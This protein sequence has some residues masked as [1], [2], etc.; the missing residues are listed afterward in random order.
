MSTRFVLLSE[1]LIGVQSP[2]LPSGMLDDLLAVA[3]ANEEQLDRI[4]ADLEQ[5]PGIPTDTRL[6]EVITR[7]VGEVPLAESIL[8]AVVNL[9]PERLEDTIQT[10]RHWREASSANAKKLPPDRLE[11]IQ[12]RL[13][14][15]IRNY[16]ALARYRKAQR[17]KTLTGKTADSVELIC[18]LRP[19]FDQSRTVVEGLIPLATLRLSYQGTDGT[20]VLEVFL[21]GE[22]L[23]DLAD[24]VDKAKQKL[25]TLREVGE[26]WVPNGWVAPE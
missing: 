4:A 7:H 19:V 24:E 9:R 8:R 1:G 13:T 14:R 25:Q 12:D 26:T 3:G 10:L 11:A 22:T 16:P 15:L 23:D 2:L 21:S 5:E 6:G 20:E 17:L 18:D